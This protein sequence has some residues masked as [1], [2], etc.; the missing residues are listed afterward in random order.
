MDHPKS[1][2]LISAVAAVSLLLAGCSAYHEAPLD[3]AAVQ[4]HLAVPS[5]RDLQAKADEI[6]HPL[7]KPI[8]LD[9]RDGMSPD[10]A[11]ILA[12][13]LNPTLRADRN[14]RDTA[15]AELIR[16]GILPNPQLSFNYD[17]VTGGNTEGTLDGW[18]LGLSW[19][20]TSLISHETKVNAAKAG[21]A[22]VN[23]DVAWQEWQ[24]AEAARTAVY[25]LL[26]LEA[27]QAVA[28]DVDR[29]LQEN[30]DV[31]HKAVD[32]HL[33]TALDLAAAEAAARDSHALLLQNERDIQHQRTQLNRAIGLPPETRVK[34]T[35]GSSL[36]SRFD[37]PP[38]AELIDGVEQRRL[39]LLGLKRGYESQDQ[40]LRA[41][42]LDQFPK[43]NIGFNRAND[44]T[45]VHTIGPAV[46]FDIPIF[47]R[48]QATIAAETAT[49]KKLFDEYIAR[50]YDARADI[51]SA[52]DDIRSI[53]EQIKDAEAAVPNLQHLVDTYREATDRGNA[54]VLSYYEAWNNL[55]RKNL[56][57]LKLKQQL[58]DNRIA[59]E[60][61][62]GRYCPD[63]AENPATQPTALA[64]SRTN[65]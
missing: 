64:E 43:I 61:A 4:Q 2:T 60:I 30:L 17:F 32:Q 31:I 6:K 44:T 24:V 7:L 63:T 39:D 18:G 26:S 10:E 38:L 37:P 1:R 25:D 35:P 33:K 62:A 58:A 22:S 23:L 16:A 57:V 27:Q 3:N 46:T 28:Q 51:S 21:V 65:P 52:I 9:P 34:L 42:I 49:R 15:Q 48:N 50:V 56:D 8:A 29:R 59:L 20:V 11:A 41:A 55:A 54:D 13:I 45:N 5:D 53:N 40:T 19:D 47:D 14:R 36:S 12:V